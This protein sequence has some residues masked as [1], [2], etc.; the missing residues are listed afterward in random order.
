MTQR[1]MSLQQ[2]ANYLGIT[3]TA[4]RQRIRRA[5]IPFIRDGRS[6]RFDI[7]DLDR[8]MAAHKVVRCKEAAANGQTT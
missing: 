3:E 5:S 6:V 4:I 1:Y 2:A 7:A 8:Y